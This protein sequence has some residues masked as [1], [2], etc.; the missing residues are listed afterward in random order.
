[1]DRSHFGGYVNVIATLSRKPGFKE[2]ITTLK[3]KWFDLESKE[4]NYTKYL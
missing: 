4:P 3:E 1:L 2:E